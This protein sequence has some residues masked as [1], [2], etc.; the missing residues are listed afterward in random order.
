MGRQSQLLVM[1]SNKL[2][3]F[4]KTRQ[5]V[6]VGAVTHS[7]SQPAVDLVDWGPLGPHLLAMAPQ[8]LR[9]RLQPEPPRSSTAEP[10]G[11]QQNRGTRQSN[12][13]MATDGWSVQ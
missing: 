7:Q 11:E 12:D 2:Q 4:A 3:T 5:S 6:T 8:D 10:F 13:P 9:H 1:V